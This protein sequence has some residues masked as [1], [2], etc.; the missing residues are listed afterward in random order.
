MGKIK[1]LRYGSELWGVMA[2]A[3]F[4]LL[5]YCGVYGALSIFGMDETVK[6]WVSRGTVLLLIGIFLTIL[7]W[8]GKKCREK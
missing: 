2:I 4:E 8:P 5:I 1:P 3:L 7:L 6:D